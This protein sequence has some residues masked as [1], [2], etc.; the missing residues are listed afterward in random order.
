MEG[1]AGRGVE[2]LGV[3]EGRGGR[4][5]TGLPLAD[6]AAH[7]ARL[8]EAA[9]DCRE[10]ATAGR[11]ARRTRARAMLCSVACLRQE[12]ARKSGREYGSRQRLQSASR[13][14]RGYGYARML[15]PAEYASARERGWRRRGPRRAS[16]ECVPADV[17]PAEGV[18]ERD[19]DPREGAVPLVPDARADRVG[20][21]EGVEEESDVRAVPHRRR[22][23]PERVREGRHEDR[24]DNRAEEG[25]DEQC[26]PEV[27]HVDEAELAQRRQRR[28]EERQPVLCGALL[29]ADEPA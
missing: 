24:V 20:C 19:T 4:E 29:P 12:H 2:G 22:P 1:V 23:R 7:H 6:V 10:I 15:T 25:R 26:P 3:T 8:P 13:D 28:A 16:M 11:A 9:R 5:G 14:Y 18:E 17:E 21:D 27:E